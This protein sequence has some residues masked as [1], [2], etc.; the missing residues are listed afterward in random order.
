[1]SKKGYSER[2]SIGFTVEQMR[3]IEEIL[4]VRA[5]QGKFQH[6]TDLIREAVNL[7]L[8]HQDDIPGTRAAITRK[9]EGRFLAVEQ[10]LREQND[11]LARMVA[12]FER[13]RK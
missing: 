4:R 1:M 3:R 10:Q 7:Y 2:L 13:R 11:L 9:L 5:K 6:K 8:S 12:F